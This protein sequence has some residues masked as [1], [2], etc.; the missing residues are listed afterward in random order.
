MWKVHHYLAILWFYGCENRKS[1]KEHGV[2]AQMEGQENH[3][4]AGNGAPEVQKCC[5]VCIL[6]FAAFENA[7][8]RFFVQSEVLQPEM[9]PKWY[10][11][12]VRNLIFVVSIF[13]ANFEANFLSSG[14]PSSPPEA[15]T[16][17]G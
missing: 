7:S 5:W 10:Q 16:R 15:G 4:I 14:L 1:K 12:E 17:G 11:N 3:N 8:H 9:V 2:F 13:A 6:R